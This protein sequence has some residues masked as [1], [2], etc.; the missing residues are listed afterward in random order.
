MD[1]SPRTSTFDHCVQLIGTIQ[2]AFDEAGLAIASNM[3]DPYTYQP[4]INAALV[5]QSPANRPNDDYYSQS[6]AYEDDHD[7]ERKP[8]TSIRR[9]TQTPER[10]LQ[11]LPQV[12]RPP[13]LWHSTAEPHDWHTLLMLAPLCFGGLL[14]LISQQLLLGATHLAEHG[15]HDMWQLIRHDGVPQLMDQ[16]LADERSL[17]VRNLGGPQLQQ[18]R[19]VL[20]RIG[21]RSDLVRILMVVP[22]AVL[23]WTY[24]GVWMVLQLNTVMVQGVPADR[25]LRWLEKSAPLLA[26]ECATL[27]IVRY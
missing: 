7:N 18:M 16:M 10:Q 5:E 21:E 22:F 25:V 15:L 13:A 8:R 27:G 14:L 26:H 2:D 11:I 24:V 19:D 17:F 4:P 3:E 6:V 20:R 23:L 9:R 1:A 12:Q